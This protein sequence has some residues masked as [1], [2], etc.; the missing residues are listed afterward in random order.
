MA[1]VRK[2]KWIS[3]G[4]RKE[5]W[6]ADYFDR[7]GKRHIK[8]FPRKKDATDFLDSVKGELRAGTHTPVS[9]SLSVEA[10]GDNWLDRCENGTVDYEPLE[11][12][13]TREYRR[14]LDAIKAD[15]IGRRK[16]AELTYADIQAFEKRLKD[17]GKSASMIRKIRASF[18]ALLSDAMEHGHVG[19]HVLRDTARN[20]KRARKDRQ[21]KEIEIPTKSEINA[22]LARASDAFKPLLVTA[23]FSG[24]RASE[25][26][27]LRWENVDLDAGVIR[28][29]ERADRYNEIGPPKTAAGNRDIPMTPMVR[30]VLKEWKLRCP[31]RGVQRDGD[32]KA[33]DAGALDLVFPNGAGNVESLGNL[34]RR[35]FAPLQVEC[36]ITTDTGR[37]DEAGEPILRARFGFHALRHAAASLFIEQGFTPK[38]LQ[39]LMGHSSVQMT[40][41]TYGHLFPNPDDDIKAFEQIEARLVSA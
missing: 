2:R 17:D 41:D 8:T 36:G 13:T 27:G 40:F 7:N 28:V 23:V 26:R 18:S 9:T 11:R 24:M 12:G 10:A 35:Q 19:R 1:N 21:R 3:G 16:L 32:G 34:Y 6:V 14:H 4:Q 33:A 29:R 37:K 5:A 38:R 31:R 15:A 30:N 39:A 25:L 22:L 20:R